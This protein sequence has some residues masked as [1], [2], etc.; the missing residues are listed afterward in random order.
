VASGDAVVQVLDI[1]PPATL[2]ATMDTRA[3]GSAP[4][5]TVTVWD[6]D[7][8]TIEYL[9]L[10]C[11]LFGYGAETGLTFKVF[12]SAST[13]TGGACR[14]EAAIRAM[15]D[16]TEDIDAAHTY[17][18]NAVDD[19]APSASGELGYATITFTDGADMDALAEGEVF[20]LRLRRNAAH[21]NDTMTGDAELWG[22]AGEES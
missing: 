22:V 4:V 12:W 21:A 13:A 1:I 7:D 2:F 9:D 10:K 20:I 11:R 5:E 19:T 17:V 14:W 15:P 6:F 18:Y 3:G 8:S 16:D